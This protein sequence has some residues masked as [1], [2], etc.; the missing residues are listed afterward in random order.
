MVSIAGVFHALFCLSAVSVIPS[1]DVFYQIIDSVWDGSCSYGGQKGDHVFAWLVVGGPPGMRLR[2]QTYGS[3]KCSILFRN[4]YHFVCT[5]CSL[6]ARHMKQ[7]L[8]AATLM[9]QPRLWGLFHK[10]M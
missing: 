2:S 4:G 8:G 6:C 1:S 3:V 10:P 9:G 7:Q 5:G